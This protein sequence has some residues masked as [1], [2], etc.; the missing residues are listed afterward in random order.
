MS[1]NELADAR[2][3]AI[4]EIS[5]DGI[6][7]ANFFGI[8]TYVNPRFC[9]LTGYDYN[10]FVG[11]HMVSIPTLRQKDLQPFLGILKDI[12]MGKITT[13]SI[14]FPYHRKD[15]SSGVGDAYA[16][17][18]KVKN[19]R[20]IIGIVKDITDQVEMEKEREQ[21]TENL[22]TLVEERTNQILDNEKMVTLAKVSSMIAHDLK[23]P[24]QVIKNAL[25]LIK[26]KPDDSNKYLGFI[27]KAVN[28]ANDLL[29]EF[30]NRGKIS[31]LKLEPIDMN[32]MVEESLLQ[33]KTT[34]KIKFKTVINTSNK[35]LL[36]RSKILRVLNNLIKNAVEAMPDGG[37]LKINVESEFNNTVINVIDT[38]S[39]IPESKLVNLFRPFQSSKEKGLGLGLPFCKD[40]VEQHGGAICVSSVLGKGTT[41]TITLPNHTENYQNISL[42]QVKATE[43]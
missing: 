4:S 41:F 5:P 27:E 23:G 11:K 7:T 31:P 14:Q 24:L 20:E 34:E 29:D 40:A 1:S 22:E 35:I 19:K 15:G 28:Q 36:D 2:F 38:G 37:D 12:I 13:T 16:S 42:E 43:A 10:D 9:T 30:R 33:V 39:G 3:N 32:K 8:I 17:T 18:L 21:Y 6:M 25:Y 26:I